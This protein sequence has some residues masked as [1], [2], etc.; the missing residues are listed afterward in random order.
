MLC[1]SSS[2]FMSIHWNCFVASNSA[3]IAASIV[4]SYKGVSYFLQTDKAHF[5]SLTWWEGPRMKILLT[6]AGLIWRYAQAA[7]SPEY[8]Y[9]AWGW[10]LIERQHKNQRNTKRNLQQWFPVQARNSALHST[11]SFPTDCSA[12]RLQIMQQKL[13]L[14]KRI[15]IAVNQKKIPSQKDLLLLPRRRQKI[16]HR[17]DLLQIHLKILRPAHRAE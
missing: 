16:R 4:R 13:N 1:S 15:F 12:L 3:T 11:A 10:K 14:W 17:D 9:P 6:V 8:E 5:L 2:V 7:V